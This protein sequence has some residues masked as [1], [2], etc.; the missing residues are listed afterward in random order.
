M[1]DADVTIGD[2]Y[3]GNMRFDVNISVAKPG[4]QL[5]TRTELKNLNSF[6]AVERATDYEIRRQIS[7]LKSGQPIKQQTRGWSE[8]EGKTFEQRSKEDAQDYRYMPDADIPPVVLTEADVAEMQADFPL[9]PADYRAKFARLKLDDSVVRVLLSHRQVAAV[10]GDILDQS[11]E[12]AARRVANLFASCLP[13]G[14][15]E[16]VSGEPDHLPS[17]THLIKLAQMLDGNE[18]SSTAG[19]EIFAEILQTDVDPLAVAESKHLL[20]VSDEGAIEAIVDQVIAAPGCAKAVADFKSGQDK[21]IG[22]LVGQ[23]MKQ[24]KGQANPALA[25]KILRQK[26]K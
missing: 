5:G 12:A 15:D 2:L 24:S 17:V 14:D 10:I 25:Q 11:G 21:V 26:L 6:R 18:V 9:M 16:T 22:F 4:D 23:V 20:Q 19:K 3:H 8:A 13:S 7:V 1:T